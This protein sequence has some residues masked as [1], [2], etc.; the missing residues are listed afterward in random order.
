VSFRDSTE[1]TRIAEERRE[2]ERRFS[3]VLA[4]LNLMSVMLDREAR[5]TYCNDSLLAVTG[6]KREEILGRSWFDVFVPPERG[7]LRALFAAILADTPE[8]MH[9]ENEILARDGSRRLVRWSNLVLRTP[10]GE[11]TGTASVGEDITERQRSEAQLRQSQKMEAVGRLAGG[12]AHDF[13]NS[14]GVILGYTELLMRQASPAQQGKLAQI[15]KAT[16]HASGLTRQLLAFSRQQIVDPK[17]LDLNAVVADLEE[18]LA[19]LIGEDIALEMAPGPDLGQV[20]ADAGQLGQVLINLCVNARDAM[21]DGGLLRIET[22]NAELDGTGG[23][24]HEPVT[25]GRYVML[26]VT[27]G[28]CGIEK[29]TLAQIFE[30]FF[31]TKAEGRGTGLGLAMVYGAVRQAGGYVWVY[32]EPGRGTTFKIYLPRIDGAVDAAAP[33]PAMPARGFE[34]ILLVEDESALR[35]IAGEILEGHGYRVMAAANGEEALAVALGYPEAIHLLVTDV[36]M[37]GMNGRV[38]TES[39][40][41]ARPGLKVLYMSGYT[42][43]VIAH[44]GVL[45][46]GTL[47]IQKPFTAVALLSQV[48]AALGGPSGGPAVLLRAS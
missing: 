7:D 30:P 22:A 40:V 4:N 11:A 43:D 32:S 24:D 20:R 15:L 34:T 28:G 21:P 44:R 29:D 8:A 2:S 3:S 12:V 35:A 16:Q 39:L 31:T 48:R 23:A 27:D 38:L 46:P 37:P 18:M 13:N 41:A 36:V 6:W 45:E 5:I 17:V 47:L 1:H 19:R 42:Q 9:H 26:A 25:A 14:L 10:S 33:E